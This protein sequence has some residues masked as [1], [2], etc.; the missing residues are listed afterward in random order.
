MSRTTKDTP[1]PTIDSLYVRVSGR[2]QRRRAG[3]G[4]GAGENPAVPKPFAFYP[5]MNATPSLHWRGWKGDNRG[6]RYDSM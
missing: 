1:E 3:G 6:E 2:Q 4:G 5:I